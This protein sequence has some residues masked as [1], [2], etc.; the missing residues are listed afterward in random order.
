MNRIYKVIW[1]K[2][3]HQ[4]VVVSELAHRDGKRSSVEKGSLRNRFAALAVCG[5]IAVFGAFGITGQQVFAA[6]NYQYIAFKAADSTRVNSTDY[7]GPDWR[8]QYTYVCREVDN[9]QTGEKEK[10]WVRQ[11]YEIELVLKERFTQSDIPDATTD[12]VI[13]AR[14]TDPNADDGDLILSYQNTLLP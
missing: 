4:Y 5:A 1:S 13:D 6:E 14:K 10:Y 9:P 11:G 8:N 7:F 12:T 2:V 3:K